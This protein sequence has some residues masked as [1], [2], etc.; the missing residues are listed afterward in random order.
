MRLEIEI[1][2]EGMKSLLSSLWDFIKKVLVF[3]FFYGRLF[4][5]PVLF[6]LALKFLLKTLGIPI[7]ICTIVMKIALIIGQIIPAAGYAGLISEDPNFEGS[8]DICF[9]GWI[10]ISILIWSNL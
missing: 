7:N 1:I 8:M 9:S 2:K 6:A 10:I 3:C 5:F 4:I